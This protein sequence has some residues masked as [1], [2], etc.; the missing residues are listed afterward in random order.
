[1]L[2]ERLP[3]FERHPLQMRPQ[4]VEVGRFEQA[5]QSVGPRLEFSLRAR[6]LKQGLMCSPV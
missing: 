3:I 2:N 6:T 1:L 4:Q 5:E